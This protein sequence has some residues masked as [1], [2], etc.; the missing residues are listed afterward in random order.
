MNEPVEAVISPVERYRRTIGATIAVCVLGYLGFVVWADLAR[1]GDAILAF[2][3]PLYVPIL[4]LTLVNYGLRYFKWA[5]LIRRLG[6]EMPARTNLLAFVAGLGLVVTPGK[7][8]ELVKP[9][10]VQ[11]VTGASMARTIPALV[12][13]RLT[14]GIAVVLLSAVG[15]ATFAPEQAWLVGA[16]MAVCA[17]VVVT[18]IVDPRRIGLVGLIS[19][20]PAGS[21]L[22]AKL[23]EASASLRTCLGPA[24]LSW[25]ILVSV[26]AWFAECVGFW[27]VFRGMG[28][29]AGL[30]VS[31]FLYAFA[32]VF[33]AP[34]PGGLGMADGALAK[35]IL[36]LVP[37]TTTGEA[38]AAT[39]LVRL[40]TLWFGVVLG[41]FVLARIDAVIE[42]GKAQ[43]RAR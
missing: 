35:G 40:A 14:D 37:G 18:L 22:A 17:A 32:T 12:T 7:A 36:D 5:W 42:D 11:Q 1:T 23:E 19:R 8:G 24:S 28:K 9:W 34:S 43:V 13:E 27:L 10:L 20:L 16:G 41:A 26:V 4:L 2:S 30:D 29:E 39:L 25:M 33:G 31:T 3:W 6:V 15:V 38:A 21:A